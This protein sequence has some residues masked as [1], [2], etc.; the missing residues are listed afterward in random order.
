MTRDDAGRGAEEGAGGRDRDKTG[1]NREKAGRKGDRALEV[2]FGVLGPWRPGTCAGDP[3]A[4]KGR[5]TA[6]CWPRLIVARR[7][8]VQVARLVEDLW[9]EPPA[10]AVGAV[11]TFVA[12]AA[13][14]LEP[15]RPPR[16]PH[17]CWSPRAPVRAAAPN[18]GPR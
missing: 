2:G 4:L 3:I 15:R 14:A 17:G 9:E 13:R 16:T 6:R 18:R 11:R 12:R 1:G 8:V 10:D 5:G 7:R